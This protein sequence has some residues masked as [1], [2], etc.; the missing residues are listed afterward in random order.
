MIRRGYGVGIVACSIGS[1]DC[2]GAVDEPV[3]LAIIF[4]F[5]RIDEGYATDGGC[6]RD[7]KELWGILDGLNLILDR[8][9]KKILIKI[10]SL[11]ALNAIMEDT[12]GNSNSAIVRRIYQTLK[13]VK[14]WEIQRIPREDNLIAD[15][16]AKTVR[17]SVTGLDHF[18]P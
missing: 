14:Q 17:T 12:S 5:K 10:D 1:S 7:H 16:L 3:P 11:E 8:R 13:R 2:V 9:F 18:G 15:S 6:E 4:G